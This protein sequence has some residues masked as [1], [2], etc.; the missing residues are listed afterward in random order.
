MKEPIIVLGLPCSDEDAAL[1]IKNGLH[2]A[3]D[4]VESARRMDSAAKAL[5]RKAK[6]HIKLDT[7]MHRIGVDDTGGLN[8]LLKALETMD[9]V[10]VSGLFTHFCAADE[11]E[12]FTLKQL[13]Q[14]RKARQ[15]VLD[16]GYCP[17]CHAAASTAMLREDFQFDMVRAGI[18]LYG[19]GVRELQGIV[20]P[21]QTLASQ[22][23]SLR[24][25]SKGE[26]VGYS[27][28][29]TAMRDSLIATVP[30]GYGDG[31]PRILSGKTDVL[32]A[33]RRAPIAGNVCMD[34]L[35]CDVTDVPQAAVGDPVVLMG[36]M[37]AEAITP[38]ELAQK[39][40]TIPY[41]IMLGFSARA[42]KRWITTQEV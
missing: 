31:Y 42:E 32:V 21:A 8:G 29:F 28:F 39:A 34:M 35:M 10:H 4:S 13:A 18:A 16:A 14:F 40:G 24:R 1:S 12:D 6:I 7:G 15:I 37:G 9:H 33:G 36:R 38:D 19:T 11:D 27:R 26:T 23:V 30:C 41:E 2:Q 5:D 25:V 22:I 20:R 3:I 17:L